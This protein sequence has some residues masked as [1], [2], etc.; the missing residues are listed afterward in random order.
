MIYR[1]GDTKTYGIGTP[2]S[3]LAQP[4]VDGVPW[5]IT[6][7]SATL[8]FVRPDGVVLTILGSIISRIPQYFDSPSS[9]TAAGEWRRWWKLIDAAGV[10][11]STPV[12]WFDV[13]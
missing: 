1:I 12:V 6:G 2:P 8:Y 10:E 3:T 11:L 7:G 13:T 5:D 9:L 4:I